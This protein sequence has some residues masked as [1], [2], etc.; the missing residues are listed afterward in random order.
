MRAELKLVITITI[1]IYV[2]C[3]AAPKQYS[4]KVTRYLYHDIVTVR[5][6]AS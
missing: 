4:F 1:N 5:S 2:A 3:M 6:E